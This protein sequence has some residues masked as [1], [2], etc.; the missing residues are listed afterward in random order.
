M[1][2]LHTFAKMQTTIN[3]IVIN[4]K[5]LSLFAP[6]PDKLPIFS[7]VMSSPA[8]FTC[9]ITTVI[10][11]DPV[12]APDGQTYERAAIEAW[13]WKNHT[14]PFNGKHMETLDLL[15]DHAM[16][17]KIKALAADPPPAYGAEEKA[18]EEAKPLLPSAKL[19]HEGLLTLSLPF[20]PEK[21]R[22]P[23]DLVLVIDRSGSMQTKCVLKDESGNAEN[24]PL[25]VLDVTKHSANVLV[26]MMDAA[27]GDRVAVVSFNSEAKLHATLQAPSASVQAAI[28]SL[29]A[30]YQTNIW[31]G[32]ELALMQLVNRPFKPAGR[33]S[34]IILLTDGVPNLRPPRGE[35]R[36]LKKLLQKYP[37]ELGT[38]QLHTVGLG[39]HLESLLL[40]ELAQEA[41]GTFNYISGPDMIGTTFVNLGA[42]VLS[43]GLDPGLVLV[44]G[45]KKSTVS[46]MRFGET[47]S[48]VVESKE[49]SIQT[50][51]GRMVP[52]EQAGSSIPSAATRDRME[53]LTVLGG[54]LASASTTRAAMR[55]VS[56]RLSQNSVVFDD[57]QGQVTEACGTEDAFK[58]W[59]Q[60]YLRAL[61]DA[62]SAF[63]CNNFRDPGIQQYGGKLFEKLRDDGEDAFVK[64]PP[65]KHA[66]SLAAARQPYYRQGYASL[67]D[68][69]DTDDVENAPVQMSAFYNRDAGCLDGGCRIRMADGSLCCAADILPGA[70]VQTPA[71]VS[72]VVLVTIQH[73]YKGALVEVSASFTLTRYHPIFLGRNWRFPCTLLPGEGGVQRQVPALGTPLFNFVLE[74]THVLQGEHGELVVTLGHG[75]DDNPVTAHR[76]FGTEAVVNQLLG[77]QRDSDGR[78]PICGA[79]RVNGNGEIFALISGSVNV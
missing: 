49:P 69:D 62:H 11:K 74:H 13:L 23:C 67:S 66:R 55:A 41:S 25:S 58:R 27:A 29:R 40:H 35:A 16:L 54:S 68:T 42:N 43:T 7:K 20:D 70:L 31:A 32:L 22:R 59:G 53:L 72:R 26:T 9:P 12:G 37:D 10:M 36:M 57:F 38:L 75:I 46:P 33:T 47:R 6:S 48:Y 64:M 3:H 34:S 56:P 21:P 19:S 44:D 61:H 65:P 28:N 73:G 79:R 17:E 50:K 63:A 39:Y 14:S 71:G 77:F 76:F 15:P 52:I 8:N 2:K 1:K 5:A 60:H 45:P 30:E 4:Q 24:S 18:A 78:T 51:M